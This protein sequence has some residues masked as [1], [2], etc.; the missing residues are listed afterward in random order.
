ME[1]LKERWKELD[2]GR[3]GMVLAQPVLFLPFLGL[4][5]TIGQ[6][7]VISYH[8]STLR[9]QT[10]GDTT[11]YSGKADGRKIKYVVSHGSVV[12][13]WLD[14]A[15]DSTY[16][17]TEDST[18]IPQTEETARFDQ[19]FFTGVE[20]R[21]GDEVWFRGAYSPYSSSWL[22]D[23]EGNNL[24]IS[25]SFGTESSKP[26]PAPGGILY[27]ARE[28]ESERRGRLADSALG[29]L[30]GIA[31]VLLVL[32]EEQLYRWQ[33][34]F[35]M[36]RPEQAEPTEWE[37]LSHWVSWIMLT[38]VAVLLYAMGAGLFRL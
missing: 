37:S 1:Y 2:R 17:V 25:I 5:L 20:I 30:L 11:V 9:Y 12:E 26:E 23:E 16:T 31:C 29:A 32:F 28:P 7:W 14:G 13:F 15:L 6:Q 33:M 19:D 3:R 10:E 4:A 18:A 21:K 27:I 22:L 34:S 36:R 24:A 35:R 38:S 8:D